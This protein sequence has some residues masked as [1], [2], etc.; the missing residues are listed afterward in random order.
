MLN[1]FIHVIM[2][3]YYGFSAMGPSVQKYLWWKKYLTQLQLVLIFINNKYLNY[4]KLF[5]LKLQFFVIMIHALVNIASECTYPKGFSWSFVIY[6][7][8]ITALFMNFYQKSYTSPKKNKI[9]N[10]KKE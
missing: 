1:S 3:S 10:S 8:L 4:F 6:G 7:I 5:I 2:Y 9:S